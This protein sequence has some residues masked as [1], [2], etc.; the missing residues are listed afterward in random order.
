MTDTEAFV[1]FVL[2]YA[3][4]RYTRDSINSFLA[5]P[6]T[7][8]TLSRWKSLFDGGQQDKILSELGQSPAQQQWSEWGSLAESE[9]E[10]NSELVLLKA[11]L[12]AYQTELAHLQTLD[13]TPLAIQAIQN[14]IAL[15][16]KGIDDTTAKLQEIEIW[17]AQHP[18]TESKP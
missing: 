7:S 11:D 1:D 12:A 5:V 9:K 18:D 17:K 15:T 8:A 14:N 10:Y 6:Q 13:K 16:Q 3:G 4:D 2:Q